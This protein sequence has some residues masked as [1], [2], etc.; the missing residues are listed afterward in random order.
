MKFCKD[1][2]WADKA[3]AKWICRHP[4]AIFRRFNL[5]TG[6]HEADP[7]PCWTNRHLAGPCGTDGDFWEPEDKPAGFV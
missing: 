2:R 7:L 4:S 1:C 3:P 6:E 5:V